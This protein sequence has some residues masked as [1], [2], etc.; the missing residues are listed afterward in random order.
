MTTVGCVLARRLRSSGSGSAAAVAQPRSLDS[1]AA[2]LPKTWSWLSPRMPTLSEAMVHVT[3]EQRAT[4][5]CHARRRCL[6]RLRAVVAVA[7]RGG[8]R[9]RGAAGR[10]PLGAAGDRAV[11][12]AHPAAAAH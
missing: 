4:Y 12:T 2:R 11:R 7:R 5:A 10:G 6:A 9:T 3:I 8:R 1:S